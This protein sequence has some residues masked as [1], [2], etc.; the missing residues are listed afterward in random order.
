MSGMIESLSDRVSELE[1]I[2]TKLCRRAGHDEWCETWPRCSQHDGARK[3]NAS[4]GEQCTT[5][6]VYRCCE[7]AEVQS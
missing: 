6:R 1:T 7:E 2:V 3:P 5:C 4:S